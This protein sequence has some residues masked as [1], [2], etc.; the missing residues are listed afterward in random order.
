MATLWQI[1]TNNSILPVEAGTTFWD[2][3]NN[4]IGSGGELLLSTQ[5]LIDKVRLKIDDKIG[6]VNFDNSEVLTALNDAQKE[7]CV[8]TLCLF[9]GQST[10]AVLALSTWV[11][12]PA[13][14][15]RLVAASSPQT[16]LRLVTQHELDYGYFSLNGVEEPEQLTNWRKATGEPSFLV[17]DLG[18]QKARIVPQPTSDVTLTLERYRLPSV[19]MSL[20]INP[21]VAPQFH[22]D[23]VVGAVAYLLDIPETEGYNKELANLQ[24]NKWEERLQFAQQSLQTNLRATTR[25]LPLLSG[26]T[27]MQ[28]NDNTNGTAPNVHTEA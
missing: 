11:E 18:T 22:S 20:T 2:H 16:D 15:I 23:L 24:R 8:Q 28:F 10:T 6:P 12:L 7:F 19:N 14:T 13:G 9:D 27:F 21:E 26:M 25:I 3:L 17:T 1:I 4:Q 5:D